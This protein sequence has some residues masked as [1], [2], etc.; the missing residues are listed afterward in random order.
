MYIWL[1]KECAVPRIFIVIVVI[2]LR[3]KFNGKRTLFKWIFL[4]L[5]S[6]VRFDDTFGVKDLV[7]DDICHRCE[8]DSQNLCQQELIHRIF[9]ICEDHQ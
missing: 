7:L 3:L 6:N 1:K 5:S 2:G 4:L 9:E 8:L